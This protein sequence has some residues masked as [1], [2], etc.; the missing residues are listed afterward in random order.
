M[1][2]V[3]VTEADMAYA[4]EPLTRVLNSAWELVVLAENAAVS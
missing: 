4:E 2:T 1:T 3:K